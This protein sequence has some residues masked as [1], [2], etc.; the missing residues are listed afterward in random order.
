MDVEFELQKPTETDDSYY[1][2]LYDED[3]NLVG[4][5]EYRYLVDLE[6]ELDD[7]EVINYLEELQSD[8][9]IYLYRVHIEA[10]YR[11]NG[12]G[13]LL[14]EYFINNLIDCPTVLYK[15]AYNVDVYQKEFY[16][17]VL[18]PSF[19]EKFGFYSVMSTDYYLN[20]N[21]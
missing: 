13:N 16:N 20:E 1:L 10:E 5:L 6:D 19:Y 7:D 14:M 8:N 2:R 15:S 12:Y 4:S 9:V 3:Y 11:G 18:L 21:I 17:T